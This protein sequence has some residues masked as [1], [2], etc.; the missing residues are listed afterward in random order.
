M[1]LFLFIYSLRKIKISFNFKTKE[2]QEVGRYGVI[3]IAIKLGLVLLVSSDR[4]FIKLFD[5]IDNVGIY[6]QIYNIGQIS[7]DSL[8]II[9]FSSIS[10][11]LNNVLTVNL[12]GSNKL[13]RVHLKIFY[14][15]FIPLLVYLILYYKEIAAVLVGHE[16]QPGRSILPYIFA[17][18]F[19]VGLLNFYELRLKFENRMKILLLGV[20]F[21]LAINALL[22]Y[23]LIPIYGYKIAACTTLI[24]YIIILLI[25]ASR[26]SFEYYSSKSNVRHLMLISSVLLIQVAAHFII[27]KYLITDVNILYSVAEGFVFVLFYAAFIYRNYK[28]RKQSRIISSAI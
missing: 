19:I 28:I 20:V 22:N 6:N 18:A 16:F 27:R 2:L 25:Y 26:V 14:Q 11:V 21:S 10:P 13:I 3:S 8:V 4:Y 23:L 1:I 17:S 9:F 5:T 24:S 15:Y 12:H 7:I